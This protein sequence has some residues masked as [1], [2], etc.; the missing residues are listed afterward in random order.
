MKGNGLTL[1]V[2]VLVAKSLCGC[3]CWGRNAK[4]AGVVGARQLSLKGIDALQGG[5]W[6]D[7]EALFA[8]ALRQN[9]SDERAHR[10][11]AEVMWNRG[12]QKAAIH[13]ME[14]SVRL[15]GGDPALLVQ[16]GGMY[17]G[18]ED[19]QAAW[20][21]STEAIDNNAALAAA[22]ALRGD[23]YRRQNKLPEALEAYHRALTEQPHFPHVQLA[24]SEVYRRQN[25][26]QRALG[27]LDSLA[28]QCRPHEIPPELHFEKGLA[29]KAL[30]RYPEA[31]S[32]L[33][34]ASQHPNASADWYFHLAEAQFLAGNTG[35]AHLALQESLA[36]VPNHPAS[37][38]LQGTIE[39]Q[40]RTL[41]AAVANRP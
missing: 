12:E 16:L 5:K 22:W 7:A 14:E 33:L 13:H 26:P 9:P 24:A 41:T 34:L 11:Y 39:R 19:L 4:E 17:L 15:S 8:D 36:R 6:E 3:A 38:D 32:A 40:T 18:R 23:I 20:E 27:T 35:S 21:C 1:L 29:Y 31:A 37:L 10:H 30:G 25:R 28:S 2:M